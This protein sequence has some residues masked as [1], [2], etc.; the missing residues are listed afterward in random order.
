MV[1]AGGGAGT[2]DGVDHRVGRRGRE[3]GGGGGGEVDPEKER[4]G[5]RERGHLGRVLVD[6]EEPGDLAGVPVVAAVRV[7]EG[8]DAVPVLERGEG[9]DQGEGLGGVRVR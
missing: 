2:A 7:G 6:V 8:E 5:G 1:G 4:G 9:E 3:G